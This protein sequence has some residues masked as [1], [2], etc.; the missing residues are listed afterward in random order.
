[1]PTPD[2]AELYSPPLAFPS[3][4]LQIAVELGIIGTLSFRFMAG[5]RKHGPAILPLPGHGNAAETCGLTSMRPPCVN[6]VIPAVHGQQIHRLADFS[7]WLTAVFVEINPQDRQHLRYHR[8]RWRPRRGE[9]PFKGFLALLRS[10][11]AR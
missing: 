5:R 6:R 7:R 2:Y 8:R 3:E 9:H 4:P 1:M 10:R 11:V